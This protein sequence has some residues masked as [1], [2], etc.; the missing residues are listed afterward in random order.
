MHPLRNRLTIAVFA[1]AAIFGPAGVEQGVTDCCSANNALS[2][3]PRVGG[4]AAAFCSLP[5][6]PRPI[7][8]RLPAKNSRLGRAKRSAMLREN[9][10]AISNLDDWGSMLTVISY[11][12]LKPDRVAPGGKLKRRF[13]RFQTLF[14]RSAVRDRDRGRDR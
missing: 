3:L 6:M 10:G 11:M 8:S 12:L 7:W 2:L 1:T 13:V 9:A 14:L 5:P 4:K